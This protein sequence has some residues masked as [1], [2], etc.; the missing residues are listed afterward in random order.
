MDILLHA[1]LQ[2]V[3]DS[4]CECADCVFYRCDYDCPMLDATI[5]VC[6]QH[7]GY[8][9]IKSTDDKE[10]TNTESSKKT[11]YFY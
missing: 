4:Q 2:F 10:S 6:D 9:T 1:L 5:R 7:K 8:W 11:E 3:P